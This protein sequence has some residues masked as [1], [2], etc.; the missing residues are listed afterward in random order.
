VI[1]LA[2]VGASFWLALATTLVSGVGLGVAIVAA[3]LAKKSADA[4][5]RSARASDR[6]AR[7]A[8]E[9]LAMAREEHAEFLRGLRARARFTLTCRLINA[10]GEDLI[11]TN[12]TDFYANF[13]VGIENVGDRPAGQTTINLLCWR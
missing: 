13:E 1:P 3:T 12:A 7:A 8:E 5:G 10:Q 9:G 11:S 6:S 2:H 4:S